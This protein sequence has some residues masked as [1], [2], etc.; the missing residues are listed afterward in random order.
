VETRFDEDRA[1]RA[2]EFFEKLLVHTKSRWARRPF[3][4]APFQRDD[5]IRPL[6]GTVTFDQDLEEWVRLYNLAWLEVA[7]KNGKSELMAGIALLLTGAD[8]EE[9]AEVYG[10]AKDTD[11]AGLVFNVAKRMLELSGL[12]GPPRS[13]LPFIIYAANRRIVYPATESFYRVIPADA[14]GNLGQD[15]HGI[16]FDEIIAQPDG[17]LWDAL[18][19]GF[20]SRGEPL[21]VAATTAGDD[22]TS[23]AQTEHD[24]SERVAADPAI[25][26][27]RFVYIRNV[28][29]GADPRDESKWELG[30]PA[31]EGGFLRKQVL[32]DECHE[33]FGPKG[34]ARA[35]R[36][37][38]Q[39]RMNQWQEVSVDAPITL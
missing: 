36:S 39:F 21:M 26:P 23:F 9:G 3:I 4:L 32:R 25:A 5:I 19:T 22:P 2:Q 10:V 15:P 11:Q 13:G 34:N 18:K 31:I 8:D 35:Q 37:F 14:L 17:G 1:D 6:F 12:G 24:F 27:R 29:K 28:P 30:N 7:R 33:A 38:M 16:L 20:G